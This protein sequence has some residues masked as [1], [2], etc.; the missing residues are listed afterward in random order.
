MEINNKIPAYISFNKDYK[1][2]KGLLYNIISYGGY[3]DVT[4]KFKESGYTVKVYSS[5]I[6]TGNIKDRLNPE[7]YGHGY[8]GEGEYTCGVKSGIS[9]SY[10]VWNGMLERVYS[11]SLHEVRP[12]YK[13]CTC[14]EGWHNYQIFAKWF[15][16]NY[17]EG[18]ELDKDI[19]SY[20][21]S[22]EKVY[23]PETC[24]FIPP[25]LNKILTCSDAIRGDSLIGTNKKI[26]KSGDFRGRYTAKCVE[27][28]GT[29]DNELLAH[30][31]Y[32]DFKLTMIKGFIEENTFGDKISEALTK[33]CKHGF[34]N[35]INSKL[36]RLKEK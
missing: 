14:F 21:L 20:C 27:Y 31:V 32:V 5:T 4:V 26:E 34:V 2:T 30:E 28:L 1:T 33:F 22:K 3:K 29:Y 13:G 12:T 15:E 36:P 18:Y 9:K 35:F 23:S 19:L 8:L 17:I 16:D 24:I 10:K 7:V 11:E 6:K 25:K